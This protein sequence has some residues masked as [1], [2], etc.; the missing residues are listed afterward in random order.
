MKENFSYIVKYWV[1]KPLFPWDLPN[2]GYGK[3]Y[4][5]HVKHGMHGRDTRSIPVVRKKIATR[6]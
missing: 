5:A 2:L 3:G 4:P 1:I 6:K